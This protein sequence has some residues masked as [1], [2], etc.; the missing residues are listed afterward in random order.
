M[1]ATCLVFLNETK[2]SAARYMIGS[3]TALK[4]VGL[5]VRDHLEVFNNSGL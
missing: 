2:R 1:V 5:H 4:S 3:M